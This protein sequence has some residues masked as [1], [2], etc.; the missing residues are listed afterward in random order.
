M[1]CFPGRSA[2]LESRT[3]FC[4]LRILFVVHM[5]RLLSA[6]EADGMAGNLELFLASHLVLTDAA[7]QEQLAQRSLRK[8]Q[9]R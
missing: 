3:G 2:R 8:H 6:G 4:I 1:S 5:P 9:P 7:K